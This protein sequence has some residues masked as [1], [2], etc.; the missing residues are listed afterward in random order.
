LR[1]YLIFDARFPDWRG[2]PPLN[3]LLSDQSMA[4]VVLRHAFENAGR[5]PPAPMPPEEVEAL[6]AMLMK[7]CGDG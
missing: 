6:R 7:E 2:V 5:P 4:G 3:A 1:P